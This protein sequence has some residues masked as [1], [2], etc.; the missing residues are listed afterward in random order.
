MDKTK[1]TIFGKRAREFIQCG[2]T[3]IM[4]AHVNKHKN[5]DGKPVY[6]GTTDIVDDSD[7]AYLI[8]QVSED[9]E[10]RTVKF[11]NIKNRGDVAQEIIFEY[12]IESGITYNERLES[13]RKIGAQEAISIERDNIFNESIERHKEAAEAIREAIENGCNLKTQILSEAAKISG[14]TR[15][16][17]VEALKFHTGENLHRHQYWQLEIGDK[18]AHKYFLNREHL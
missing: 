11:E 16:R 13:C 3:L 18:N 5:D 1:S 15:K 17:L 2:G 14:L 7:C 9:G 8:D 12:S 4:L 6:A 10:K